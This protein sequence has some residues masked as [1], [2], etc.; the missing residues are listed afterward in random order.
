MKLIEDHLEKSFK[1][2]LGKQI[3]V[4]KGPFIKTKYTGIRPEVFIH[5]ARLIDFDGKMPDGSKTSRININGPSTFKGFAEERP[6]RIEILISCTSG[7]YALLQDIFGLLAPT[8]LLALQSLPAIPLGNTPDNSTKLTFANFTKNIHQAE[9]VHIEDDDKDFYK[10]EIVVYL[11]GF[12][13]VYVTK[14]GGFRITSA[15]GP[16]LKIKKERRK[17]LRKPTKRASK[18]QQ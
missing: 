4:I 9:L 16:K 7:K 8:T 13:D 3:P 17:P 15:T 11:T 6:G 2:A 5:A 18:K 12:I 10:G 14:R 1:K